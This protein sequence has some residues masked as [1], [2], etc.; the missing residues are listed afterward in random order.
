MNALM[1]IR[2]VFFGL[3]LFTIVAMTFAL[4]YLQETLGLPPCPLCITQ[5]VFVILVGLFALLA[6]LH[7]PQGWGRRLY[8]ALCLLSACAGGAVAMRHIWLQSLPEELAPA[9]GPSLGYMLETLPLAETF[10]VVM[11]GDG[12]C[13]ETVWTFMGMSIPQQTLI[14]FVVMAAVSVFQMLRK[15]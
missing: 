14:V 12:N 11:M 3:F 6:A 5:R 13:A 4:V 8:A 10:S 1:Q 2:P 7:N 15:N 9:C